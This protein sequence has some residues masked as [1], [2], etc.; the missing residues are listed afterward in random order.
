MCRISVFIPKGKS[1]PS[2]VEL[3]PMLQVLEVNGDT[4]KDGVG[5]SILDRE[6]KT[7]KQS[8]EASDL[9]IDG[10]LYEFLAEHYTGQKLLGHVRFATS[11]KGSK[12]DQNAHPFTF[13]SITLV[14]NGHF[15]NWKAVLKKY[16][17][18]EDIEVDSE[19]FAWRLSQIVEAHKDTNPFLTLEDIQ[20]C[21]LE[22]EGSFA[23]AIYDSLAD[24]VW[25]IPHQNDLNLFDFG[26]AWFINTSPAINNILN[27]ASNMLSFIT[28]NAYDFKPVS[29]IPNG[30]AYTIN[31]GGLKEI[32]KIDIPKPVTHTY[33]SPVVTT[34]SKTSVSTQSVL[35]VIEEKEA[36]MK[37]FGLRFLGFR[38][39]ITEIP[40]FISYD[41]ITKE[42]LVTLREFLEYLKAAGFLEQ[43]TEKADY[44][45][46]IFAV[47][48]NE[49]T[50]ARKTVPT[51]K[52]PFWLNSL[53]TLMQVPV[54]PE[55]E[56]YQ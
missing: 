26:Y 50:Y 32:G 1:A 21:V 20:A 30:F 47:A 51:F 31:K 44:W 42:N 35:A 48:G 37:E 46:Q 43:L 55:N 14:H 23:L 18:Q 38:D 9:M 34:H 16:E 33:Y 39:L 25:V 2:L 24:V 22:F 6:V 12:R 45:Q 49:Y 17:C 5:V 7:L 41:S 36:L 4:N 40:G 3:L 15:S 53:E 19:A 29:K 28:R 56:T 11:G 10:S 8:R 13:G 27:Y 54:P 52:K